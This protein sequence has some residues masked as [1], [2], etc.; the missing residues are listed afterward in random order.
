M[1]VESKPALKGERGVSMLALIFFF[2]LINDTEYSY[3]LLQI[4][5]KI[6][7]GSVG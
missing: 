7:A 6:H 3:E 4:Q 2:S 5:L 1:M